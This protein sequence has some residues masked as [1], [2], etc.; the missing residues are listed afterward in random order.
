[1]SV[2][3]QY[4][5]GEITEVRTLRG[6]KEFLVEG[7]GF[8]KWIDEKTLRRTAENEVDKANSVNLP[9]NPTPQNP[10]A[11]LLHDDSTI[12]PIHEIDVEERLH[13]SNSL[14]FEDVSEDEAGTKPG[15][16]PDLFADDKA[17]VDGPTQPLDEVE[18]TSSTAL[19]NKMQR[20]AYKLEANLDPRVAEYMDLVEGDSQLREAAWSDVRQKALR[21]RREGRVHVKTCNPE[22]IEASVDGD[23]GTYDTIIVRGNVFDLGGQ[24]VTAWSCN[25]G[26]GSW[27]F[28]RKVSFIGRFCSHAY[29]AYLEMQ[30]QSNKGKKQWKRKKSSHHSCPS[31]GSR[32]FEADPV[33]GEGECLDCGS[34]IDNNAQD[35]LRSERGLEWTPH[36]YDR[37]GDSLYPD[38]VHRAS[39]LGRPGGWSSPLDPS[40]DSLPFDPEKH[41]HDNYLGLSDEELRESLGL[42]DHDYS[43]QSSNRYLANPALLLPLL[44]E[45][46]GAAA[47]GGAVEGLGAGGAAAGEGA[48]AGGLA[49]AIPG[50]LG[51][52]GGS[53]QQ[54][55]S[56]GGSNIDLDLDPAALRARTER[57]YSSRGES[58]PKEADALRLKPFRLT[59]DF[60]FND[61]EDDH[62][63]TDVEEDDRVTTG[64][65]QITIEHLSSREAGYSTSDEY[66]NWQDQQM[67]K[68]QQDNYPHDPNSAG[69]TPPWE[70]QYLGP[71]DTHTEEEY[72][73]NYPW[74]D[75]TPSW[76]RDHHGSIHVTNFVE[77]YP[78]ADQIGEKEDQ[79]LWSALDNWRPRRRASKLSRFFEADALPFDGSG[80]V[81]KDWFSS[82]EDWLKTHQAPMHDVTEGDGITKYT[83]DEDLPQQRASSLKQFF[84]AP[85]R[86]RTIARERNFKTEGPGDPNDPDWMWDE[87][88]GPEDD[89][90][91]EG[92]EWDDNQ[93]RYVWS[94]RKSSMKKVAGRQFSLREQ[95][96]LINERHPLGA[97]NLDELDLE[98]THY[99]A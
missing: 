10:A 52:G 64:P 93:G 44:E 68:E 13:P 18:K 73:Q 79:A 86:R 35:E 81:F 15:P 8:S 99:L 70:S 17:D 50:M 6:H 16:N 27:A 66:W 97:R 39:T 75:K 58:M 98:G 76:V 33:S 62:Y 12:Q 43:R 30:S 29:A 92:K 80:P 49:D 94:R 55:S 22:A 78:Y 47:A 53:K 48:A 95:Q 41:N 90:W 21:L 25:C 59:P 42:D 45:A 87:E 56:S 1:M 67:K 46:G 5:S 82:S 3:T 83:E 37:P 77:Q 14:T 54:D 96:E 9:Y 51:G 63:F 31:C 84:A 91:E 65:D 88:G 89:G 28:K 60:V 57:L 36:G 32:G 19:L 4:G 20:E 11:V 71:E 69:Y 74:R 26:W 85:S 2:D 23:T 7:V 24:S 38:S 40:R 72:K 61:T 34:I